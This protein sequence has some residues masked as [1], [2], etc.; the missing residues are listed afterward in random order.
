MTSI[1]FFVFVFVF[2]SSELSLARRPQSGVRHCELF[3]KKKILELR[4]RQTQTYSVDL[5]SVVIVTLHA[6]L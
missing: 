5:I 3:K 6:L 2:I 4:R 1:G